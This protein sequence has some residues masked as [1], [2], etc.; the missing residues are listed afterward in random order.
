MLLLELIKMSLRENL[1]NCLL[2][3]F[4]GKHCVL[5]YHPG[6]AENLFQQKIDSGSIGKEEK[7]TDYAWSFVE[8]LVL[9]MV[10][11][12][13]RSACFQ[14][15]LTVL[16]YINLLC[17]LH[18]AFQEKK[19]SGLLGMCVGRCLWKHL[20][21]SFERLLPGVKGWEMQVHRLREKGY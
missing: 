17:W 10:R 1:F 19:V 18:E 9:V 5:P 12:P 20:C 3:H 21:S 7:L 11:E 13:S 4:A 2:T 14:F 6:Q 8:T 16:N 15:S